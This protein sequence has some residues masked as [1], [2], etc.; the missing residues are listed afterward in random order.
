[1]YDYFSLSPK[2]QK[3]VIEATAL[4]IVVDPII[5]EKDL[6]VTI[7]LHALFSNS[8]PNNILLRG[9]TSL[10]K[11]YGIIERFS[12]NI[13]VIIDRANFEGNISL[14][15]LAALDKAELEDILKA[16]Y[17]KAQDLLKFQILP[18]LSQKFKEI[19]KQEIAVKVSQDTYLSLKVLYP[20]L[21]QEKLSFI[22]PKID[23]NFG[24]W[25][26]SESSTTQKI[27]S[28]VH[29]EIK[30]L[31]TMDVDVRAV[32]PLRTLFEKATLLHR[33]VN[34]PT[35]MPISLRLS[36]HYYDLHQL[37][38]KGCLK[39]PLKHIHLLKEVITYK[40]MLF[41]APEAKYEEIFKNGIKILP[42]ESRIK[43]FTRDYKKMTE[44]FFSSAPSFEQVI[45][46][47]VEIERDINVVIE[48]A[49]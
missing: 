17:Q 25:E 12:E 42:D 4:K 10:S 24:V 34:R 8:V 46:T 36:R 48:K 28:F 43:E 7:I 20:S 26:G 22:E 3:L 35:D 33:E 6:W 19:T 37:I 5:V 32:S 41:S 29:K 14:N 9:D 39:E 44:M 40:Q 1:M 13:D 49:I 2:D 30:T 38:I 27:T 31:N 47:L 21:F 23:I 11:A 45:S 16:V 15:E 18:L